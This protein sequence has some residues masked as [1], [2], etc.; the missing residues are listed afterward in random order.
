MSHVIDSALSVELPSGEKY[1]VVT[2]SLAGVTRSDTAR[3]ASF[4]KTTVTH[5][6][7]E[8]FSYSCLAVTHLF[9]LPPLHLSLIYHVDC[10]GGQLPPHS[11]EL[12]V[13]FGAMKIVTELPPPPPPGTC[14]SVDPPTVSRDHRP[15]QT[16]C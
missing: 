15:P 2:C 16:Y 14:S 5:F 13:G 9:R 6:S 10:L 3:H 1:G 12:S 8:T 7:L 11:Y 4:T